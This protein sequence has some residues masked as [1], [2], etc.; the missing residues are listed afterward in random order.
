MRRSTFGLRPKTQTTHGLLSGFER[1]GVEFKPFSVRKCER[2][3]AVSLPGPV[4]LSVAWRWRCR[5]VV[6]AVVSLSPTGLWTL[7]CHNLQPSQAD[8]WVGGDWERC[9]VAQGV[10]R[11]SSLASQQS[12]ILPDVPAKHKAQQRSLAKSGNFCLQSE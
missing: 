4:R 5:G 7:A 6:A 2:A 9:A 1:T 3:S 10:K 11:V 12:P 8:D